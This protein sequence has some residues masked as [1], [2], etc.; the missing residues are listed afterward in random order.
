MADLPAGAAAQLDVAAG[1]AVD[2]HLPPACVRVF[3]DAG[4]GA[5]R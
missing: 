3:P 4:A 1:A 5:A 2:L